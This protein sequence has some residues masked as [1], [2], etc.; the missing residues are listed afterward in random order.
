MLKK[1]NE[2]LLE[3]RDGAIDFERKNASGDTEFL[4]LSMLFILAIPLQGFF[5]NLPFASAGELGSTIFLAASFLS[6]LIVLTAAAVICGGYWLVKTGMAYSTANEFKLSNYLPDPSENQMR[7]GYLW[8]SY[9][10]SVVVASIITGLAIAVT[11]WKFFLPIVIVLAI[12][13]GLM[14][15]T[16]RVFLLKQKII[17]HENNSNAHKEERT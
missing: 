6:Y 7:K 8:F 2:K 17:S 16:R 11:Y 15:I 13:W 4:S 1:F 12:V 9:I 3:S 10:V 5:F 14:Y